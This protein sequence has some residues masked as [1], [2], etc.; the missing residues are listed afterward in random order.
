MKK[1]LCSAVLAGL[2]VFCLSTTS[3]A[4]GMLKKRGGSGNG[5]TSGYHQDHNYG[6]HKDGN[7]G[8]INALNSQDSDD[9]EGTDQWANHT[10]HHRHHQHHHKGDKGS[11]NP[12]E[13]FDNIIFFTERVD[14]DNPNTNSEDNTALTDNIDGANVVPEPMTVALMGMGLGGMF[15]NRRKKSAVS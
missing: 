13:G 14:P 3:W 6:S 12:D 8:S 4:M 7:N 15:L 5:E 1:F 11:D 9:P 2:A 10:R